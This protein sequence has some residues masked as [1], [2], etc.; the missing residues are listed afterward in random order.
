VHGRTA[1]VNLG[2]KLFALGLAL[3][4]VRSL[5]WSCQLEEETALHFVCV[6]GRI[7]SPNFGMIFFKGP[8]KKKKDAAKTKLLIF[9]GGG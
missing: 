2:L 4:R 7:G 6:Q 8:P 9:R 1:V 5:N 3:S